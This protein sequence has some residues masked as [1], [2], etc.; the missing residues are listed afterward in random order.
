MILRQAWKVSWWITRLS[1]RT[2][3][4]AGW[5]LLLTVLAFQ[6]HL[7]SS[8]HVALPEFVR[9]KIEERLATQGVRLELGGGRIDFGGHVR[10]DDVRVG[11]LSLEAPLATASSVYAHLDLF[12]LLIAQVEID[13]VQVSG[14]DLHL[15]A[16]HSLSGVD[17]V[18]VG[19]VDLTVRLEGREIVLSHLGG[20]IR[21]IPLLVSGRLPKPREPAG[22]VDPIDWIQTVTRGWLGLAR[23]L[24]AADGYLSAFETPRLHLQLLP[25]AGGATQARVEISASGIDVAKLPGGLTGQ[26]RG[27][28]LAT[29]VPL[30]ELGRRTLVL[31]GAV[32]SLKLPREIS[33]EGLAFRLSGTP[34]GAHG[35]DPRLLDLQLGSL[36]WREIEVG[37]LAATAAQPAPGRFDLALSLTLAGA[38]WSLHGSV[39]PGTGT[40]AVTLDGRVEAATLVFAGRQIG[41]ELGGLLI[42]AQPAP[43]TVSASFGPGWKL[44]GARG[45]L[46]SGFV[47]VGGVPIDEAGTEF[48]YDGN[49]VVCDQLVL[50]LGDSLAHGSYE[51]DARTLDFR[52]LLTGGLRPMGIDKWFHSWWRD[53]WH[54][55][56]FNA[57]LPVADVDV[58]GR[59]GDLTATQVFVQADCADTGLKGVAFD[60]LRT[61]LY[62]RPH[63]FDILHFDVALA[64]QGAQGWLSRAMDLKR[65]TWNAMEF[66]VDSTLPLETIVALFKEESAELLAP[67]Q[68]SSPP[69]LRLSG[70]VDS[71]GSPAGKQERIDINLSSLGA[72]TYHG[73][74]LA[75]LKVN[76]L[77]RDD[78]LE[79]PMLAA[80]FAE[81]QAVGHATL[82]GPAEARRL[83]FDITLSKAKLGAVTQAVGQLQLKA[84]APPAPVTEK[85]DKAARL[86]QER[87]DQGLFDFKLAA[88][89]LYTDF[90][91]FKGSGHAKVS[92]SELGQLNLFGPLSA[93]LRGSFVNLGS[94]SLTTADAPFELQGDHVRFE[95]LRIS[96][97]SALIQAKGY[98]RLRD[99][100]LD[101]S[102]KVFPFDESSSVLGS[103]VGFVLTPLSKVLE[104]KLHG[105]LNNPTWVF[106]Y[107]P[108]RLLNTLIGGDKPNPQETVPAPVP[109]AR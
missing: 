3:L 42:P 90:F 104:V 25:A 51:M 95:E 106:A 4:W 67:Y 58:L 56:T 103:A 9:H 1:A 59:W 26:L 49:R 18:M 100:S 77:L 14:L 27:V 13:E 37:P 11:P 82:Q 38:P 97:P 28:R 88:E 91:S 52:F 47:M 54:T 33:A 76:A 19:G 105:S 62:L 48:T 79:L 8:R 44:T 64:G 22:A 66:D 6:L 69:K 45:R 85:P 46:H 107:G 98:Y 84:G 65:N 43:L 24:Q 80:V 7:L 108:S 101:F 55:F 73:F 86:R 96:G 10:L 57:A 16:I 35:F 5:L 78:R 89:G 61:R 53:F 87:L 92:G 29:T 99:G 34:G 31:D 36:R 68:F 12:K 60:R 50:R 72:M 83:A 74:P 2:V 81:G 63:W 71:A 23:Q 20:Y 30:D 17:E 39:E 41:R 32:D 70:R 40:A 21:Q 93:A 15:P 75:D 102:T 94:F 109:D